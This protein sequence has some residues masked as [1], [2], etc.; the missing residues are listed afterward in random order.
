MLTIIT[1]VPNEKT[2]GSQN[3][4]AEIAAAKAEVES[5]EKE[6]EIK[7]APAIEEVAAANKIEEP[8]KVIESEKPM[9][10]ENG[11]TTKAEQEKQ[12]STIEKDLCE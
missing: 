6:T 4:K 11:A 5:V 9:F 7:T 10:R 12:A 3:D 2:E 8:T 1:H